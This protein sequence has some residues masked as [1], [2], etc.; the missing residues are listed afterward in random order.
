M[1]SWPR[2]R[3]SSWPRAAPHSWG[4]PV[5]SN[6]SSA[7]ASDPRALFLLINTGVKNKRPALQRIANTWGANEGALKAWQD[8]PITQHHGELLARCAMEAL[9]L[10]DDLSL[11]PR[12]RGRN[13]N[14]QARRQ[15]GETKVKYMTQAPGRHLLN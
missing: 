7:G 1:V 8:T 4:A 9:M 12:A 13:S 5:R 6:S 3:V 2:P 10:K 15:P 14:T 11:L